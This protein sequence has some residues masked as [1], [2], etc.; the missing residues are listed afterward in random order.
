MKE[1]IDKIKQ[2]KEFSQLPDSIVERAAELSKGDVKDSRALLRKYFGV[3]LTNRVLKS[4]WGFEEVL[5]FHLS[6]KKRDYEV[7]YKEIFEVIGPVKS[8]ID[9][10]A[11][12]NGFSYKVLRRI[13]GDVNYLA[14]EAVGQ[15]VSNMNNYFKDRGLEM[16]HAIKEDLFNV[17]KIL[18]LLSQLEKPRATFMFQVVDALENMEKNFSKKFISEIFKEC[19]FL[20][21]TLPTE[22]LGGR[23]QFLVQ[24]KWIVEYLEDNFKILKDFQMNGERVLCVRKK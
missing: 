19:E 12:V 22:S 6:T 3:F 15:L 1:I 17:E 23:K 10:G 16:A 7:F 24:R 18:K 21:L 8:V 4:G 11:G 20:V 13:F 9:L 2:K 5:N 14:I